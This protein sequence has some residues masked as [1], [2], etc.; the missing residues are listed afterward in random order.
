LKTQKQPK[1]KLRDWAKKT[2]KTE[3]KLARL[4]NTALDYAVFD[5]FQANKAGN[6]KPRSSNASIAI[7]G[8]CIKKGYI[9]YTNTR[10]LI[11]NR[12]KNH[13]PDILNKLPIERLKTVTTTKVCRLFYKAGIDRFYIAIPEQIPTPTKPTREIIALDPGVRSFQ[14]FYDGE[15]VGEIGKD[16]YLK[17]RRLQN[18]IDKLQ[19]KSLECTYY[20]KNKFK[21]ARARLEE[22]IKNIV[23][24][25]HKKACN[26]LSKYKVV[27]LP[28]FKVKK[29]IGG[30]PKKVRRSLLVLAHFKFK[31]RLAQKASETG[32]RLI[33]CN[34]AYTSK[35]C[36]GCGVLNDKLGSS[37]IFN[38]GNCRLSIDRDINGARN[39]ML[40]VLRGGSSNSPNGEVSA[41]KTPDSEKEI[42]VSEVVLDSSVRDNSPIGEPK[43]T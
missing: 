4:P 3:I 39:I 28:E 42:F 2:F 20:Q 32:M 24:D 34:E 15:S 12:Y 14:T 9:Y 33:I 40:R 43:F 41:V 1:Y 10:S 18:Q 36:T 38:C 35:T 7:D 22:R 29:M 23:G 31:L 8:R 11:R 16:L 5:A 21:K 19:Q 30:L 27:L 25:C 13:L 37:K 17:I 6:A 26:F